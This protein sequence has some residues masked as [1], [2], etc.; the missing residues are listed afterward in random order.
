MGENVMDK[1]VPDSPTV[2]LEL[3]QSLNREYERV[4]KQLCKVA[5]DYEQLKITSG[6]RIAN[7]NNKLE[8]YR[9]LDMEGT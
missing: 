5:L 3:W 8:K 1:F 7:L 2:P 6:N 4:A 9:S